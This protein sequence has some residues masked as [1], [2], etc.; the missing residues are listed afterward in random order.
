MSK[1]KYKKVINVRKVDN[2]NII[3]LSVKHNQNYFANNK[4]VHNCYRGNLAVK[5]Y[6]FGDTDVTL[7]KGKAIAQIVVYELIQPTVEWSDEVTTT[8]RGSNGFGSSDA[9]GDNK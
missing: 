4:C 6:N 2:Q 3:H 8:S 5:L 7:P 9:P 1:T